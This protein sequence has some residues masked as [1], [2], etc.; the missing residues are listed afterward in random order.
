[1]S[2]YICDSGH[3]ECCY[4]GRHCPACDAIKSDVKLQDRIDELEKELSEAR[5]EIRLLESHE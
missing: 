5:D 2:L 3:D 1:M 4:E